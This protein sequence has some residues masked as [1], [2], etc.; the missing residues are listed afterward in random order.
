M[1]GDSQNV[2]LQRMVLNKVLI[3][4]VNEKSYFVIHSKESL[5]YLC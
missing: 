2:F 3:A 5:L 4:T 1:Q